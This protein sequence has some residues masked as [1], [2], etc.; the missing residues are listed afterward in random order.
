MKTATRIFSGLFLAL[1]ILSFVAFLSGYTHQGAL[2][3]VC[4]AM[5]AILVT[6][7]SDDQVREETEE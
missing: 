4:L 3:L 2:S 7:N 5:F 1:F 6:D